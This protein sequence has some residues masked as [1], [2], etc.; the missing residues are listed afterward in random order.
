M[1]RGHIRWRDG[2][3]LA[4]YPPFYD[5]TIKIAGRSN[6]REL[7]RLWAHSLVRSEMK[8][9]EDDEEELGPVLH[10]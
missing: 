10:R 2:D 7:L 3:N 6:R 5:A 9:G 8:Q 1:F 4:G